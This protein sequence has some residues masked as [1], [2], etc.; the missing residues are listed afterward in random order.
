[1]AS[2]RARNPRFIRCRRAWGRGR[3]N[4]DDAPTGE[5]GTRVALPEETVV[6]FAGLVGF[7]AYVVFAVPLAHDWM[8]SRRAAAGML[9]ITRAPPRRTR[10]S[11]RSRPRKNSSDDESRYDTDGRDVASFG[12]L[13]ERGTSVSSAYT[14]DID[15]ERATRGVPSRD[16][17]VRFFSPR[18]RRSR[19]V[20]SRAVRL[21]GLRPSR[22]VHARRAMSSAVG[23]KDAKRWTSAAE[24]HLRASF[25]WECSCQCRLR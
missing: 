20:P 15:G 7:L 18:T 8:V 3:E 16:S 10:S 4:R 21:A 25:R 22:S 19:A 24:R 2:P 23:C 14:F 11:P 1:M 5:G 13:L 9:G 17:A 6:A 12:L